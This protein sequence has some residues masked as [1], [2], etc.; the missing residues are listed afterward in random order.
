MSLWSGQTIRGCAT[1]VNSAA[2]NSSRLL[3]KKPA[4]CCFCRLLC[5][6]TRLQIV[7]AV[8]F[9]RRH[10]FVATFLPGTRILRQLSQHT[11]HLPD[12]RGDG[13]TARSNEVDTDVAGLRGVLAHFLPRELQWI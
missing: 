8:V 7:V 12:V 1:P 9:V 4:R 11:R 13:A 6:R 5:A 3:P 2:D 10:R